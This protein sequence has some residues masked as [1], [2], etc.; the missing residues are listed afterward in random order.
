MLSIDNEYNTNSEY[1]LFR[2]QDALTDFLFVI[3]SIWRCYVLKE[4]SEFGDGGDGGGL[5]NREH[6][7]ITNPL[8]KTLIMY[9]PIAFECQR[10]A[11]Y[12]VVTMAALSA[13]AGHWLTPDAIQVPKIATSR[14]TDPRTSIRT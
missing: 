5:L 3:S 2:F 11:P 13:D 1:H 4:Y 12:D 10:A 7:D 14:R 9:R 6:K 8:L